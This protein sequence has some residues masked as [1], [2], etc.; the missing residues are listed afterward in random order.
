MRI[1]GLVH[2]LMRCEKHD[3]LE[4][5]K[6]DAI[7]LF[8]FRSSCAIINRVGVEDSLFGGAVWGLNHLSGS[9]YD[10]AMHS[11]NARMSLIG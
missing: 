5:M 11:D 1:L 10:L 7:F 3:F 8:L 4:K 2:V 9:L 6:N